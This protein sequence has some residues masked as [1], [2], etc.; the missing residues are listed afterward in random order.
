MSPFARIQASDAQAQRTRQTACWVALVL[1]VILLINYNA[2]RMTVRGTGLGSAK[3]AGAIASKGFTTLASGGRLTTAAAMQ[4]SS[5]CVSTYKVPPDTATAMCQGFCSVKFKKFHCMWC[6]CRACEFCAKGVE[7]INEAAKDAPPPSP[8]SE[9]SFV[10]QD[11]DPLRASPSPPPL[12]ATTVLS[13][14]EQTISVNETAMAPASSSSSMGVSDASAA[15]SV[16]NDTANSSSSA[17]S[18]AS[19]L[20]A[21]QITNMARSQEDGRSSAKADGRNVTASPVGQETNTSNETSPNEASPKSIEDAP[22]TGSNQDRVAEL[23]ALLAAAKAES[24][25]GQQAAPT[26]P[27]QDTGPQPTDSSAATTN[28]QAVGDPRAQDS[29][30]EAFEKELLDEL[31]PGPAP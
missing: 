25:K 7:A 13:L 9:A 31:A 12:N 8:P 4:G 21:Q 18:R 3:T 15:A 28:N 1:G 6:K 29:D 2:T 22:K 30:G 16:A 17:P 14:G 5:Q 27:K 23:E 10:H 11:L 26:T 24:A 19:S 20:E